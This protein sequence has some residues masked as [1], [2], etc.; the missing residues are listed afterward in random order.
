M[1]QGKTVKRVT[2]WVGRLKS[3]NYIIQATANV[4]MSFN[5][6]KGWFI[7][8]R[9]GYLLN[10]SSSDSSL[11][12]WFWFGFLWQHTSVCDSTSYIQATIL[13]IIKCLL[14]CVQPHCFY[15]FFSTLVWCVGMYP[16][17]IGE[18]VRSWCHCVGERQLLSYKWVQSDIGG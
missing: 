10:R 18:A 17:S 15:I 2:L 1:L 5:I 8:G 4:L 7:N 3:H 16:G 6:P 9:E 11:L 12:K 13:F 14:N